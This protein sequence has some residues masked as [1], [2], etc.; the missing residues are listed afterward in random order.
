MNLNE[1]FSKPFTFT[2]R[3]KFVPCET[4]SIWLICLICLTTEELGRKGSITLHKLHLANWISKSEANKQYFLEWALG[5]QAFIP[6]IHLDPIF[7]RAIDIGKGF[8]FFQ[9]SGDRLIITSKGCSVAKQI[10]EHKA[11]SQEIF[12]ITSSKKQITNS[13]IAKA[14]RL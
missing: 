7:D 13:N 11:M 9:L 1:F 8:G 4:R 6:D 10:R 3:A 14:F 5:E 12:R 2:Q